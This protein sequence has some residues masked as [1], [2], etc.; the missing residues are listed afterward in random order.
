M[1]LCQKLKELVLL[2]KMCGISEKFCLIIDIIGILYQEQLIHSILV[3]ICGKSCIN[4]VQTILK[5]GGKT[6]E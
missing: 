5:Q 3:R 6:K 1:Y 2:L 4:C